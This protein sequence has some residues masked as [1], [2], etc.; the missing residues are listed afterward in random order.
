KQIVVKPLTRA[1]A[2][3]TTIAWKHG[4]TK[5]DYPET[6]NQRLVRMKI[7]SLH[8]TGA[9]LLLRGIKI[10]RNGYIIQELNLPPQSKPFEPPMSYPPDP[11]VMV[12]SVTMPSLFSKEPQTGYLA[13]GL[14][15]PTVSIQPMMMFQSDST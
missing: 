9:P 6:V 10:V 5:L 13:P 1:D 2:E 4:R 14:H 7:T 12:A 3:N 11:R 8:Q 15:L